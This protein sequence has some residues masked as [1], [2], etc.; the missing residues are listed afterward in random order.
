MVYHETQLSTL[1]SV[2][3]LYTI[4]YFEYYRD[5]A[6][7]GES[8]DFWEFLYI[9][10]GEIAATCGGELVELHAGQAVLYRP[11]EFHALKA[12]GVSAPNTI[13]ISFASRSA[14]LD[15]LAGRVIPITA[16]ARPVIGQI[17]SE[18][19]MS[20]ST[21]LGDPCYTR[22]EMRPE[23]PIGSLQLIRMDI[24][25]LF[26]MMLRDS[27]STEARPAPAELRG[28][29]KQNEERAILLEAERYI[30]AHIDEPLTMERIAAASG[31]SA[32]LLNRLF[33]QYT[34]FGVIGCL[35][36][37]RIREA[38]R[39]IRETDYNFTQIAEKTG[40]QSI[41]YFSRTFKQI[42]GMTPTEYAIS[43]KAMSAPDRQ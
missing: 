21:D 6:F 36:R 28:V 14:A 30:D 39:M 43:V 42:E 15:S 1:V 29:N 35:R 37:A 19:R 17:L 12:N 4:H 3:S 32:S 16:D 20:F 9:D 7:E 5:Y 26:I 10:K 40:F 33:K 25:R 31:M 13:V 18:A 8:H 11:L 34:G 38:C 22:L 24:E 27:A 23:M 41:H 2:D